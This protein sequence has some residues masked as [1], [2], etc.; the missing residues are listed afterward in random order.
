MSNQK[1]STSLIRQ[2]F[3]LLLIIILA[4]LILS[5]T[6]PYLSGVLGAIALF[7]I[8]KKSM[9]KMRAKKWN[10][11]FASSLILFISTILIILPVFTI[12]YLMTNKIGQAVK[13]SEQLVKAFKN[14]LVI[15]ED[16]LGFELASQLDPNSVTDWVSSSLKGLATGTFDVFIAL[17]IMYFLLYY[18][19]INYKKL[20]QTLEAYVPIGVENFKRIGNEAYQKVK[21]NAIGIPLVALFQGLIA[22]IGFW[23]FDVPNPWF[24]FVITSVG[25]VLPFVGTAIGILPV[26]IILFAEG[27]TAS[28]IGIL[29]Y[30]FVVVGA[31]DNLIRLYVLKKMADE[32]PLITLFG[33]IIGVPLFGFIGL[34]FGPLLISLFLLIMK[35][36][37]E[38]YGKESKIE[39]HEKII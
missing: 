22:L 8:F 11:F 36:Y 6:F 24:W 37:K 20:Q 18:M 4:G 17:T 34:I 10:P 1:I 19:L 35:I 5:K 29:V 25:S 16:Y 26:S 32:H 2:I 28:G 14:Q 13:N 7:V 15:I 21:A 39:T 12:V 3:T 27:A 30:G 31:S 33:V 38:E 9:A 23:I